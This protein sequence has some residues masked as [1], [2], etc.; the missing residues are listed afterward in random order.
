MPQKA[1][2]KDDPSLLAGMNEKERKKLHSKGIHCHLTSCVPAAPLVQ[3]KNG[4]N[5]T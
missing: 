5:T 2:E 4:R 1:I 3:P